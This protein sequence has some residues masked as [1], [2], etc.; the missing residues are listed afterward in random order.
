MLQVLALIIP[1][2][3]AG[4]VSP[5]LL[6]EQTLML[7][8]GRRDGLAFA[9]GAAGVLVL[10]ICALVLFGRSIELPKAPHLSA[11]L[12]IALGL[13]LVLLALRI[14]SRTPEQDAAAAPSEPKQRGIGGAIAF[15]CV[16]MVTNFT[17]LA[18]LIPA[19]K[20]IA[21]SSLDLVER[22]VASL[23]L[24]FLAAIPL[25]AP[26]ALTILAPGTATQV[27]GRIGEFISSNGRRASVVLLAGIGA[28][29]LVRGV[30]RLA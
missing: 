19:A 23:V 10:F 18:L 6:T 20:E 3:L 11:S 17:T 12:D 9:A 28:Y 25:W 26:I 13:L 1:L 16:S 27:L 2:G 24:A 4:A 8:R 30:V 21:A 22:G 5:L 7:S 15:G 14:H 29:L